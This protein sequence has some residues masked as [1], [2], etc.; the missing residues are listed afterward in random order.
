MVYKT[1]FQS[2]NIAN[3]HYSFLENHIPVGI[4]YEKTKNYKP[5]T[6]LLK[7]SLSPRRERARVR[8][9]VAHSLCL[10]TDN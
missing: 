9:R 8:G 10:K 4:F 6:I 2:S 1:I 3:F 5:K 7:S